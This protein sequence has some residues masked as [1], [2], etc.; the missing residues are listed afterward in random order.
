MPS[1]L[2]DVG[3][4]G[5][6]GFQDLADLAQHLAAHDEFGQEVGAFLV[7]LAHH[8][9]GLGGEVEDLVGVFALG[10]HVVDDLKGF[11][12]L[13]VRHGF[14]EFVHHRAPSRVALRVPRQRSAVT[15]RMSEPTLRV[16]R[17]RAMC[18][19]SPCTS[20]AASMTASA[21]VG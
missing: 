14:Y 17:L 7:A 8:L 15:L 10:E 4:G 20:C 16:T 6:E 1:F 5:Q 9:H 12:L 13:H 11:L 3:L 19:D 18:T 21:M 2:A